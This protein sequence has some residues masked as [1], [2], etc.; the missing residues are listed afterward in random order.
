MLAIIG[1]GPN[2]SQLRSRAAYDLRC[3]EDQL[4][5][6]KLDKRTRGV[7][8]CG[9]Q[10]T[11]VWLCSGESAPAGPSMSMSTSYGRPSD[12]QCTWMMNVESVP[13]R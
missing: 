4:Q 12:G 2:E 9:R 8:G 5:L 3:A 11:Y 13:M 7:Y 6:M 10:A 1:C